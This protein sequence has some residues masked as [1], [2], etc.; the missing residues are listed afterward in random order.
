VVNI[1]NGKSVECLV[2]DYG[3][4]EWTGRELDMSSYAFGQISDLNDGLINVKIYERD[5]ERY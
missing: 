3:P 1:E 4:E 5:L 2:N